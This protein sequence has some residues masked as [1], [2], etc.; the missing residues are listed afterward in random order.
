MGR[1][2]GGKGAEDDEGCGVEEEDAFCWVLTRVDTYDRYGFV[3][4]TGCEFDVAAWPGFAVT[5]E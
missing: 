2:A 5:A 3:L 1:D 4:L